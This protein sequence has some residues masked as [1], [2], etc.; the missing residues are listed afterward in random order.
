MSLPNIQINHQQLFRK[1]I[2]RCE[3]DDEPVYQKIL[4]F[5]LCSGSRS[6]NSLAT[7]TSLVPPCRGRASP[8]VIYALVVIVSMVNSGNTYSI[9]EPK[10]QIDSHFDSTADGRQ[11]TI[12]DR[13]GIISWSLSVSQ[14]KHLILHH[15]NDYLHKH[16]RFGIVQASHPRYILRI[17]RAC[18][19]RRSFRFTIHH[20]NG[21]R[22]VRFM[23][24]EG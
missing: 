11:G 24:Y 8:Y 3:C 16:L 7:T 4:R 2:Q 15:K 23:D 1:K 12:N 17:I 21:K 14:G 9:V 13:L 5:F 19:I 10:I 20:R 6:L 18:I 22:F